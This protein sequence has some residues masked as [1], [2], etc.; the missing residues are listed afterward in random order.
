M[1]GIRFACLKGFTVSQNIQSIVLCFGS[2]SKF[3]LHS[4]VY[5]PDPLQSYVPVRY[6]FLCQGIL[7]TIGYCKDRHTVFI[8][9]F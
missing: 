3:C 6:R 5:L 1:E 2:G 8:C 9:L 7:K 4:I